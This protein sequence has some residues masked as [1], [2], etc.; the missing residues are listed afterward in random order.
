ME[1]TKIPFRHKYVSPRL[2]MIVVVILV[3]GTLPLL[4]QQGAGDN[5]Y[6]DPACI[7]DDENFVKLFDFLALVA[8]ALGCFVLPLVWPF[9]PGVTREWT[10]SSPSRRWWILATVFIGAFVLFVFLPPQL[11]RIGLLPPNVGL[12]FFDH[13]G[14]VRPRYL[15]CDLTSIP[16]DYGFL[17][18]FRWNP[19]PNSLIQYWWAQLAVLG[20]WAVLFGGLYLL[21]TTIAPARRLEALGK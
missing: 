14:N 1:T 7:P 10:W 17:F 4:A 5:T 8:A 6:I 12:Y 2:A 19:G 20:L 18:A 15:T 21:T 9:F 3:M 11:A 16:R 13:L